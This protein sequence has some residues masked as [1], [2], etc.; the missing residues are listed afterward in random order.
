MSDTKKDSRNLKEK[1]LDLKNR[2]EKIID[3]LPDATFIINKEEK[4]KAWNPA[5]EELMN[6]K[7]E[8]VIGK[9]SL[10]Y[11]IPLYGEKRP[12]LINLA[13]NSHKELEDKYSFI[14]KKGDILSAEVF[15]P[16][17][18]RGGIYLSAKAKP[19]YD[20][21]GNIVGAIETIRDITPRKIT[22]QKLERKIREL[23]CLYNII[24]L[25]ETP[26]ISVEDILIESLEE[27]RNAMQFHSI[28][29]VRIV[30]NHKNYSTSNFSD[31]PW[32]ISDKI[33]INNKKLLIEVYYLENK[34]FLE[35]EKDLLKKILV[36]IKAFFELKLGW[37]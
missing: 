10:D 11:S 1:Y 32:K 26:N 36:Q 14:D 22:E 28:C 4:I 13:I 8:E 33:K 20:I 16:H 23:K 5:M 37:L 29:C 7:A 35:E 17:L 31:A 3:F 25:F 24:K 19:L 34:S 12:F 9:Y 21:Q 6:V 2:F 30:F 18:K 27:I 15:V